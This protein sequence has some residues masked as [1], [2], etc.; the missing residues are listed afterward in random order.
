[1]NLRDFVHES[2]R[3]SNTRMER[4]H[5]FDVLRDAIHSLM[6]GL[7]Q[8]NLIY[9][10]GS[11]TMRRSNGTTIKVTTAYEIMVDRKLKGKLAY[12]SEQFHMDS[13][14]ATVEKLKEVLAP[15]MQSPVLH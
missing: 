1:M 2:K 13:L 8:W 5:C 15:Y 11:I 4:W 10:K 9:H 14:D 3:G 12:K 7:P 6:D